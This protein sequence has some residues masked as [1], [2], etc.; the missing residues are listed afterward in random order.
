MQNIFK[1][2]L[3]GLVFTLLGTFSYA[4]GLEN[5]IVEKYYV[6]DAVDAAGS[7]GALPVG[8]VT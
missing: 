7:S 1:K 5:I 8:S 3:L 4:Q 2:Y 6:S